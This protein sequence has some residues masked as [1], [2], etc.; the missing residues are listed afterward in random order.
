MDNA[1]KLL[2]GKFPRAVGTPHQWVVH[3]EGEFDVYFNTVNG[4]RNA[5][6]SVSHRPVGKPRILDKVSIDLDTKQK[7]EG[8]P[9][10]DGDT[11]PEDVIVARMQDDIHIAEEILAEVCHDAR[12]LA[13]RA[14][15][16]GIPPV[17]VFSGLGIHVHLLYKEATEDIKQKLGSTARKY[18]GALNLETA[19]RNVGLNGD[20]K[21]I[22]RVPNAERVYV[23]EGKDIH[24][25]CGIYTIP[26]TP[27]ELQNITP[28]KLV[29]WSKSPRD[30]EVPDD[31]ERPEMEIQPEYV[32]DQPDPDEIEQRGVDESHV[33]NDI[34]IYILKE[35]LKMPCMYERIQ[36]PEPDHQ[37]RQ[38]VVVMLFNLGMKPKEVVNLFR[39][40][41]WV[42]WNESITHSQVEQ[43]Y[44]RGYADM[45]CA[46]ARMKGF[47]TVHEQ[48]KDPEV[49]NPSD[50]PCY[51]WG[52]GKAEWK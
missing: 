40:I 45:S 32:Q 46:S 43:I 11:P 9:V 3:S 20:E 31:I 16:D 4:H 2:F 44:N 42:D 38:N 8:W 29:Q 25:G 30:I 48:G 23:E 51:G 27:K 28:K 39:R 41:G 15:E 6:A 18:A 22:M 47:C 12:Q 17:G 26:L 52:G 50:C 5:Y 21:K 49:E 7:D 13:S 24:R 14:V 37:V 36:Q 35:Y 34:L 19:D 1:Q 33:N 10:F